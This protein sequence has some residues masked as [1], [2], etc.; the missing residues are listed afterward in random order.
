[1][2]SLLARP[3]PSLEEDAVAPLE[4]EAVEM[5]VEPREVPEDLAAAAA[6]SI[7]PRG[8]PAPPPAMPKYPAALC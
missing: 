1:M 3:N 2:I 7:P 6:N 5:K 4:A 8:A